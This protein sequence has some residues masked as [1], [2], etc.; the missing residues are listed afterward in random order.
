MTAYFPD[1]VRKQPDPG[2]LNWINL[3]GHE[4]PAF[5]GRDVLLCFFSSSSVPCLQTLRLL[6]ELLPTFGTEVLVAGVCSPR[7]DR[8]R[9]VQ[10]VRRAI[11]RLSVRMPVIHDRSGELRRDYAVDTL[12]TLVSLRADGAFSR[13]VGEPDVR[14]LR[15]VLEELRGDGEVGDTGP[16]RILGPRVGAAPA[17]ATPMFHGALRFPTVIKPLPGAGQRWAVAD[18][19][20]HQVVLLDDSGVEQ[21]RFGA[22]VPGHRDGSAAQ[23]CFYSPHGLVCSSDAIY[24][25]DTGN[26][27]IRRIDVTEHRVTTVAGTGRRGYGLP[28][29][30]R[31]ALSSALSSPWDLELD[32]ASIYFANAGSHQIGVYNCMDDSV[33][34]LAGSGEAG[35]Q[36]GPGGGARLSQP[37]HLALEES[38]DRL[39]FTDSDS[40]LVRSLTLDETARVSTLAQ[41]AEDPAPAAARSPYHLQYPL[42]IAWVEG[43]L[44]VADCYNDRVMQVAL[45]GDGVIDMPA[46]SGRLAPLCEPM[47]VYAEDVDRVLLVDTN[48]HRIV[49]YLA[50]PDGA[51]E[52]WPR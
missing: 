38:G 46:W 13:H 18:C 19:G 35:T 47:G 28:R 8:E 51:V 37:A 33:R 21:A 41:P 23:A 16:V 7:F 3:E 36:D 50:G 25:A 48:N 42:G 52:Q 24:V 45:R 44:L 1:H 39:F 26:H 4:R 49:H 15:S 32:G 6:N 34:R 2:V 11:A 27:A 10:N 30:P 20:H 40:G 17:L 5:A 9:D 14:R 31:N 29:E 12:P 43:T 22:G